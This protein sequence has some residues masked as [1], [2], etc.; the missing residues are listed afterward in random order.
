MRGEEAFN[1]K[2]RGARGEGQGRCWLRG[3]GGKGRGARAVLVARLLGEGARGEGGA[4]LA[5]ARA[6]FGARL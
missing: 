2:G 4:V 6:V 3:S 1:R 5:G